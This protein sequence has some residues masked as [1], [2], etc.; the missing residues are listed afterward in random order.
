MRECGV[1]HVNERE[2]AS[3]SLLRQWCERV[4]GAGYRGTG[5]AEHDALIDWVVE[6]VRAIPG[7]AVRT[8]EYEL[9]GWHPVPEGDLEHAGTLRAGDDEIAVAGAVPY[10]LPTTNAGPLAYVPR[11]ES[12]SDALAGKVVLRD[13][14][15]FA[16]PY[17][18]LFGQHIHLTPD[19][20][21]LR[22]QVWDRPGLANTVLHDDLLAAGAAGAAGVVF[23]FDL[24]REQI[25]GYYEPTWARTTACPRCSSA[26]TNAIS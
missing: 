17:D 26:S 24:P 15:V 14:P 6:Q 23:A 12:I 25:A 16:L 22:G 10:S 1:T 19:T 7:F 2:L 4:C 8:D 5:T 13:F 3:E 11:G 21:E 18:L 9:L 20:D